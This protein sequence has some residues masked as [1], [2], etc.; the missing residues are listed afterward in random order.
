VTALA[1]IN[2]TAPHHIH[3]GDAVAW[4]RSLPSASLDAIVTDP[5][6]PETTESYGRI[7]VAEWRAMMDA[8]VEESRR[9]LKPRG[10]IAMVLQPN[11]E[12]VGRMRSWLWRF[13]ADWYD[14]WNCPQDMWQWNPAA[15]PTVHCRR[16]NGLTRPSVKAVVWLGSEDCYRAQDEVLWGQSERTKQASRTE[17]ALERRPSGQSIRLDRMLATADDR[18]GATPY[19]LLPVANT[20]SNGDASD[21]DG[22]RTPYDLAAWWVRYICPPGGVIGEPFAGSGTMLRAALKQGRRAVGCEILERRIAKALDLCERDS[23][24]QVLAIGGAS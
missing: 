7:T 23:V 14:Q 3:H 21:G 6:Y 11:S 9:V 2:G 4:M 18:G 16:E 15:A 17:R 1:V 22:G 12:R 24:Q 13:M 20:S 5:P 8:I 10:S 19:N